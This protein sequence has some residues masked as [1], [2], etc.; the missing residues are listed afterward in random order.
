MIYEG[1]YAFLNDREPAR[2]YLKANAEAVLAA[3][4]DEHRIKKEDVGV[5]ACVDRVGR[6]DRDRALIDRH[7]CRRPVYLSMGSDDG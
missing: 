4:G 7:C 3:Y 1:K 6:P 5:G 2:E